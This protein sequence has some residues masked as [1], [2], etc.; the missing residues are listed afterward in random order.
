MT[1]DHM[2]PKANHLCCNNIYCI[3]EAPVAAPPFHACQVYDVY[4]VAFVFH[5]QIVNFLDI[6]RVIFVTAKFLRSGQHY[7]AFCASAL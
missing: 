3:S 2:T 6:H 1:S 5:L 4:H 7:G